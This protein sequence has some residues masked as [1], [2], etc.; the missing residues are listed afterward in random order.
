VKG[1]GAISVQVKG[2]GAIPV[3]VKGGGAI[4]TISIQD[5]TSGKTFIYCHNFIK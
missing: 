2:G 3:Q 5:K 4:P 1:G